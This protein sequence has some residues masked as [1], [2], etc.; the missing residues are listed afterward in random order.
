MIQLCLFN[1][2][3]ISKTPKP[4]L[5]PYR[6]YLYM[7]PNALNLYLSSA[8][9]LSCCSSSCT[10]NKIQSETMVFLPE[11]PPPLSFLCIVALLLV[12]V[13]C[14]YLIID[15]ISED[16]LTLIPDQDLPT[17]NQSSS[18]FHL[19]VEELQEITC[20]YHKVGASTSTC[21]ICLENLRQAEVCRVL[22]ACHHEFHAQCIDPWLSTRL[23]CP[24]CRA[25]FRSTQSSFRGWRELLSDE[26]TLGNCIYAC[27]VIERN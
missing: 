18:Y 16:R 9:Y 5:K 23:T 15:F 19:S 14:C 20:L 13:C 24:T 10:Q 2:Q 21:A 11:L 22:P 26:N 3:K 7:E 6:Y 27:I 17:V 4:N 12:Y 8:L 1:P 25:P